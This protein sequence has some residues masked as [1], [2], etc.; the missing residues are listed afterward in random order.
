MSQL[1]EVR[2]LITEFR[3]ENR[4]TKAVN[5]VSFSLKRGRTLGI[6]GESGSGK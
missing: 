6:V 1:L 3:S 4:I 2:N 5:D